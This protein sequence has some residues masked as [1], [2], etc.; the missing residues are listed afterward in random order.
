[1]WLC[2]PCI[3]QERPAGGCVDR[4][5]HRSARPV[6]AKLVLSRLRVQA[7]GDFSPEESRTIYLI[8]LDWGIFLICLLRKVLF[9]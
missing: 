5:S 3:P 1:M 6:E 9:L 8:Y 4:A 7:L 2:R